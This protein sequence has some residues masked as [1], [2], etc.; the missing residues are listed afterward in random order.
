MNVK[1]I[2]K[3]QLSTI[4]EESRTETAHGKV[5]PFYGWGIEKHPSTSPLICQLVI[6]PTSQA[7]DFRLAAAGHPPSSI[8]LC[9]SNPD[10]SKSSLEVLMNSVRRP[11]ATH[12]PSWQSTTT[13]ESF[14]RQSMEYAKK[15]IADLVSYLTNFK[16]MG[17]GH[18]MMPKGQVRCSGGT[19]RPT[20]N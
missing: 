13:Q 2:I 1:E 17:V 5:H 8:I 15:G 7:K 11:V 18:E 12:S 16:M 3:D 20:N 4:Q 19:T 9:N 6:S 10:R 14:K